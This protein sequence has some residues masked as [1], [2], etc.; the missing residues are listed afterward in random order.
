MKSNNKK[1]IVV[2]DLKNGISKNNM[3]PWHYKE[4]F[5]FFKEKTLNNACVMGFNTFSEIANIMGYPNKTT[6]LLPARKCYVLTRTKK[7]YETDNVVQITDISEI[8]QNKNIFFIGGVSVYDMALEQADVGYITRIKKDYDCDK[9]FNNDKLIKNFKLDTILNETE[10]LIFEK[11][12]K[13]EN[14]SIN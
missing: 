3:I 8:N 9:F 7:I 6:Y 12:I 13:N 1:F 5:K 10:D 4:D 11:W 14:E 2:I